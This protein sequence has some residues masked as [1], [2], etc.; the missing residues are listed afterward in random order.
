MHCDR[1]D[2]CRLSI[3]VLILA[4]IAPMT[5]MA[6]APTTSPAETAAAPL[7]VIYCLSPTCQKCREASQ[8]VAAAEQRF[9]AKIRVE[10]LNIHETQA[11]ERM[12]ALEEQYGSEGTAPPKIFVGR[13]HLAG[14]EAIAARLD[15]V[16]TQE[17]EHHQSKP[18][19]GQPAA[20]QPDAEGSSLL[21]RFA[22]FRF[23][24]V[25]VAGL[26]DGINPCAFTTIVFLLSMISYLGKT[27]QQLAIVGITFT[28]A[29]FATYFT[30]GLGLLQ[31]IKIFAVNRGISLA[32]TYS[33]A[34]LTIGLGL[35]SF[36]DGVRF[37][38]HGEVPKGALGLPASVKAGIHRVIRSGL[39][40]RNLVIGT[41]GVGCL[42]SLLESVC[43]GQVYLPTI[44]LVVQTTSQRLHAIGFLL[45]YNL[46]FI[47]P[48]AVMVLVTYFG[49]RSDRLGN[50]A[51][52]HLGVFKFLLA[53]LFFGLA[54]LLLLTM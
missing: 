10:R 38:R 16:I 18:A 47:V 30:L 2:R 45:L 32:L 33:M 14:L 46:M 11:F 34:A 29:V 40:T 53:G 26:L 19:A 25:A 4:V 52:E 5:V 22:S 20:S 43:T 13:Q 44:M 27:R 41:F 8:L 9:G 24:T 51:R 21:R 1:R 12:L 3:A 23:T 54:T 35:W 7:P 50:L 17:L 48:L 42:V 6:D 36:I 15:A 49:V 39:R 37:M 31:A 28:V